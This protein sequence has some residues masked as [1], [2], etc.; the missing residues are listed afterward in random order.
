MKKFLKTLM[1]CL[2]ILPC[3]LVL[4]ACGG[5]PDQVKVNT[6]GSYKASDMATLNATVAAATE[7]QTAAFKS[8]RMSMHMEY[9]YEGQKVKQ[10]VHGSF[11]YD[12]ST[13]K[14]SAMYIKMD[15]AGTKMELYADAEYFYTKMGDIAA[16][17]PLADAEFD[18]MDFDTYV[19]TLAASGDITTYL[20]EL[21]ILGEDA[22]TIEK[23]TKGTTEKYKLSYSDAMDGSENACYIVFENNALVGI[24]AT[25]TAPGFSQEA[26]VEGF[27]GTLTA[28]AWTATALLA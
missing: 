10:E 25:S 28:P 5:N 4:A 16:K 20:D 9:E 22:F 19:A 7:A 3:V 15:M 12:A 18:G 14:Y 21:T 27:T 23:A 13:G 1:I 11:A 24:K 26:Q 17:Q 8:F 2:V 6:K